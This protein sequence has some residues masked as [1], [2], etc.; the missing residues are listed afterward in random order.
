MK[1]PRRGFLQLAAVAAALPALPRIARAQAY[2]ARPVRILV[3]FAAGG[4]TDIIARLERIP[5]TFEHSPRAE[6]SSCI[7]VG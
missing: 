2:P 6:R 7:L 4:G 1:L 3:G 5:V